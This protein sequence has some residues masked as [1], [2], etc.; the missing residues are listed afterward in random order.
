M[1]KTIDTTA[2]I[3]STAARYIIGLTMLIACAQLSIPL[4]PVPITM[5]TFAVLLISL[6][7]PAKESMRIIVSYILAG[8]LGAP[9]FAGYSGG[10]HVLLGPTGGY[11]IGFCVCAYVV[12]KVKHT[13]N[14][15]FNLFVIGMI[16]SLCIFLPGISSL[17]LLHNLGWEKAVAVGFVPFIIPGIIKALLA[18]VIVKD[19]QAQ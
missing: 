10:F 16:G 19:G 11:L 15:S 3:N 2:I 18:S 6:C 5:H 1:I 4:Q 8:L 7:Y 13:I 9:V 17:A 14:C 12:G